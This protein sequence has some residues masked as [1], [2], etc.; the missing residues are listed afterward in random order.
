MDDR[1]PYAARTILG[2]L[3]PSSNT[4]LEPI[5]AAMLAGVSGISAH[6]ARF[7][8]TEISL[9]AEA[10]AQFDNGEIL[11]AAELLSH[12]RCQVI[13]WSGTSSGWLGF[14]NDLRLCAAIRRNTGALACTSVLALNEVLQST[15]VRR[16][17]L[18]SPFRRDVQQAVQRNYAHLGIH[19]VAE[20]HLDLRDN[21]SF[22]DVDEE[23]IRSMARQVMAGPAAERPQAI[24]IFCT[25]LRAAPLAAEL[26]AELGVPVYDTIATAVWKSLKLAGRD[27]REVRHWGSL[28]SL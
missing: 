5:S 19:C 11:A 1:T 26:E 23:Q 17:G 21:F 7:R 25:N 20:R 24:A 22:S 8:V 18:V 12:T 28:F 9:A 4:V 15:G 3:T 14:D 13:A 16:L 27:T 10:L 2:M 6:F